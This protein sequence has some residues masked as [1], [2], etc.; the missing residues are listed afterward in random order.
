MIFFLQIDLFEE[1]K[2]K[3]NALQ[4]EIAVTDKAID[5]MVYKLY[6]LSEEEIKIVEQS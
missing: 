4:Q 1:N 2:Q 3:A 5:A 6:E